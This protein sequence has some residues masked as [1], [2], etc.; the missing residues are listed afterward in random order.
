VRAGRVVVG[1]VLLLTLAGCGAGAG[2]AGSP[3]ASWVAPTSPVTAAASPAGATASPLAPQAKASPSRSAAPGSTLAARMAAAR[4]FIASKPGTI[5]LVV[6]DRVTGAVWRAGDTTQLNWTASTIKL[7][8]ASAILEA[9]HARR[10]TLTA[11]DEKNLHL[12]LVNSDNDATTALWTTFHG[13]GMLTRFRTT[14][15]MSTLGVVPGHDVLWR[16]LHCSAQDLANLMSYVLDKMDAGDRD[17]LVTALRGVASFQHWGVWG[18]GT[19]LNPG[20][21]DGWAQKPDGGVTHWV[22]HSVGFA[23]PGERYVVAVMYRLPA[24]GTLRQGAQTTTDLV[25]TVF[26]ARTPAAITIPAG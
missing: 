21:K 8:I 20:N 17:V 24:S 10:V 2:A 19:S 23:G 4:R 11:D 9:R 7:A 12:S 22:T 18:A 14:Y 26:G 25:G 3:S 1:T 16:S 5:G 6:R 13:A 15:G